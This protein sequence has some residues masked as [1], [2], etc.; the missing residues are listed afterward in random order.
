MNDIVKSLVFS[1]GEFEVFYHLSFRTREGYSFKTEGNPISDPE[2]VLGLAIS[3]ESQGYFPKIHQTI[4]S[5]RGTP[6]FGSR[7]VF[8]YDLK[9]KDLEKRLKQ[10]KVA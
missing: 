2:K 9:R 5:S 3:L 8:H 1:E 6:A 10:R 4:V 7:K